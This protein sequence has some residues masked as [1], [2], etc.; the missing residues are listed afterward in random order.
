MSASKLSIMLAGICGNTASALVASCYE[1][2]DRPMPVSTTSQGPLGELDLVSL[3]DFKFSGWDYRSDTLASVIAAQTDLPALSSSALEKLTSVRPHAALRTVLDIPKEENSDNSFAPNDLGTAIDQLENDILTERKAADAD[4]TVVIYL[5]SPHS[6]SP[7]ALSSAFSLRPITWY[8]AETAYPA[9]PSSLI[10]GLAAVRS[11]SHFVD[12]TP[13]TALESPLLCK[14]AEEANVQLAGRDGSTGQTYLKLWL[15]EALLLRG[16]KV[17]GWYS[18][19]VIGNHDG[20]VLSMPDH[21]VIK[22]ADKHDGLEALLGYTVPDHHVTIDYVPGW[23]DRKESWDAVSAEGWLS[24]KIELRV[25]WRGTDSLLAVPVLVDIIRL[26]EY[27]A[28]HELSGL[29]PELGFFFKRPL[30][31][32]G[33][34]PSS[35]YT[36]MVSAYTGLSSRK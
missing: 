8:E 16:I 11:G 36:E 33:R 1:L 2:T 30:N 31:R 32:E 21:S 12:F 29:R 25:N 23:G 6:S 22:L 4:T 19:N 17:N 13:G 7:Q 10:Y 28:R 35:L 9:L 3:N 14:A 18:T 20:Y 26:V 27:G 5:G 15:A 24:S 34:S